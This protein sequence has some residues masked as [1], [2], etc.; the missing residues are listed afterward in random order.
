V[1]VLIGAAR[2]ASGPSGAASNTATDVQGYLA[3]IVRNERSTGNRL[4]LATD[5][6][7]ELLLPQRIA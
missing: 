5:K 2:A 6:L 1:Y 3:L 7:E 4:V